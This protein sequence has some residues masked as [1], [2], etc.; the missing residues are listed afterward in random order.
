VTVLG[1]MQAG[2][3]RNPRRATLLSTVKR[4]QSRKK[5]ESMTTSMTSVPE[6]ISEYMAKIGAREARQ[7]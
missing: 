6:E 3:L 2:A 1:L 4:L 7:G 5:L